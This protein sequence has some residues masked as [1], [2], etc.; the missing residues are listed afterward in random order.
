MNH[1]PLD[2]HLIN[3]LKVVSKFISLFVTLVGFVVLIGWYFD[4]QVLK[5]ILPESV[6]MK[7][8]T[9]LGFVVSGLALNFLHSTRKLKRRISQGLALAIALLGL[10]T[11]SQYLLGWNLG[12]DQLLFTDKSAAIATSYPGRMSLISALNFSLMGSALW[13]CADRSKCYRQVQIVALVTALTSLQVLIGYIYGIKPSFGLSLFTHTAIH[14]A[15]TFLLLS[16]GT[17]LVAPSEGLMGLIISNSAGGITARVLLPA[18]IIIPF[19][20]GGL[21]VLG[22]KVGW[23]D[24]AFGLSLHVIGNVTAFTGL[25]WYCA[26]GLYRL[27][28]KRQRAEEALRT[29]Y[30]ELEVRVEKRTAE[31]SQANQVLEQEI[32]ERL[33]TEAAL[34][35]SLR[36]M[37]DMKFALDQSS[38]MAITDARGIITEVNDKFCELSGYSREELIGQNHRIINS[39][40]HSKTFFEQMWTTI[41]QG[42]VWQGEIKNHAKDGTYYWVATTIVPFLDDTGKPYQYIAIRFDI[43]N[44]KETQEALRQSEE[45]FRRAILD[46]PLP[47]MLHTEDGEILQLNHTWI[48]ITGYSIKDIPTIADWTER[49]Y[50]SRQEQVQSQIN[51]LYRLNSRIAE[52]EYTIATSTGETRIWD[53]YSAPLGHLPDGRSLV[54]STGFDV[55]GRKQAESQLRR[56]AFYDGLTGLANRALFM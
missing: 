44:L 10:L 50:G 18:A 12:I 31:L 38:I 29:A 52:G 19:S 17:L 15:I 35:Q 2:Q 53:F 41:S 5:S 23:F 32:A 16:I 54:I 30:S 34:Q 7:P 40:Y 49:A 4:I 43:T 20:L 55:T 26:K 28:M 9:A 22:E 1:S 33:R 47:I 48:E 42:Q 6:S 39:G 46:A 27:D 36:Q 11:M 45:R 25:I 37:A 51:S 21:R 13:L 3:V 14:T 8:N 56:N 24:H